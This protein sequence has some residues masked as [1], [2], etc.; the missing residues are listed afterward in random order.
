M[1]ATFSFVVVL[2][3]CSCPAAE[4]AQFPRI[5]KDKVPTKVTEV[6]NKAADLQISDQDEIR[7]GQEVS[8]RV[9][10]RYGVVQDPKV[11]EYVGLTGNL[12]AKAS[13]RKDLPYNFI[14]LDTDG[15]NAFAAPGGFIHITRG[16]LSLIRDE[17]QLAGVLA[18]EIIHVTE[19]HTIKA[20]QKNKAIQMGAGETSITS[21]QAVFDRFV[22]LT[23]RMVLAGFGRAEEMESDTAAI[24]LVAKI[25]Y[26]P[27]GLE[28]FLRVLKERNSGSEV[29]QGLFA[30]HPEMD[31]RLQKLD[32]LAK[33]Q[34]EAGITLQDRYTKNIQYKPVALTEIAVVADGTS[35]LAE[36]KPKDDSKEK[37][38]EKST[39]EKKPSRFSLS[40]LSNPMGGGQD[41]KQ[42]AAV[43]GSGGSRGVDKERE[44]KGGANPAA[45]A[46]TIAPES[47]ERFRKEGNL[48]QP[49]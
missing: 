23:T 8:A 21:N 13:T 20:I 27:Q 4:P 49:S 40:R 39:E 44:A 29:K 2:L 14:V 12:L 31:E 34:K 26:A 15:V 30:S 35:G 32:A 22:E 36:G 5:L 10:L 37:K 45:V 19:R 1:R 43:T 24:P 16:A 46:V 25:G 33:D 17:S 6:A 18:H 11:H 7:L 41:T 42:S 38:D 47:L 3:L 48:K 28:Q 9:R